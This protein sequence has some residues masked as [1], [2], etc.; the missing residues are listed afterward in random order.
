M[1]LCGSAAHIRAA[2][3]IFKLKARGG[4]IKFWFWESAFAGIARKADF[5]NG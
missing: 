1:N 2:A 5:I 3:E 4:L